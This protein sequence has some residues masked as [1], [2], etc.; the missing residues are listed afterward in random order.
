V[1]CSRSK[2]KISQVSTLSLLLE[3]ST[4]EGDGARFGSNTMKE[5][6]KLK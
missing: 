5:N 4:E 1:L 6:I 3:H 2:L